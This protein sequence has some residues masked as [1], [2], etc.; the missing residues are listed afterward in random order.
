MER[1]GLAAPAYF[2]EGHFREGYGKHGGARVL[3]TNASLPQGVAVASGPL[4]D[5]A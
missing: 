5:L 1:L 2:R 3:R 4:I